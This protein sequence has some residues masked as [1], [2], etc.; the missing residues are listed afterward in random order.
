MSNLVELLTALGYTHS[1]AVIIDED[2]NM[3]LVETGVKKFPEY[4]LILS[5]DLPNGKFSHGNHELVVMKTGRTRCPGP[6]V[7]NLAEILQLLADLSNERWCFIQMVAN[8]FFPISE[9]SQ[10]TAVK[11][12]VSQKTDCMGALCVV[13]ITTQNGVGDITVLTLEDANRIVNN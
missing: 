3:W 2:R 8:D 5:S 4:P 10:W 13:E 11:G 12:K 9:V 1:A 6:V 7:R